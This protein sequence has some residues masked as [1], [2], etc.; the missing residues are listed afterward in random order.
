MKTDVEAA[1][2][3]WTISFVKTRLTD[4]VT[5]VISSTTDTI[6]TMTKDH[7]TQDDEQLISESP[8]GT[9]YVLLQSFQL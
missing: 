4:Q 3:G 5:T 2:T 9:Y 1:T 6:I 7:M 8:L